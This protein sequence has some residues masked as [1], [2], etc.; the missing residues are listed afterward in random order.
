MIERAPLTAAVAVL[1]LVVGY[2]AQ[3]SRMCFVAGFR[4]FLLVRDRE[5]LRGFFAFVAT[6]WVLTTALYSVGLMRK[7][8]PEYGGT[9]LGSSEGVRPGAGGSSGSGSRGGGT[10][11]AYNDGIR[12]L[13][14]TPALDRFMLVT[15]AGGWV[16]G[17]LSTFAGGCVMRQH[18]LAAQGNRDSLFYLLGFFSAVPVFYLFFERLFARLY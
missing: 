2:L 8:A 10:G 13:F 3:R 17:I 4:D 6:I 12:H 1:G 5:L 11:P 15:F 9:V 14:L 16:I 7:G 18:V